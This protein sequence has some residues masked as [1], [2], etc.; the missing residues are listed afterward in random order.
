MRER[1]DKEK[2]LLEQL[3]EAKGNEATEADAK[4]GKGGKGGKGAAKSPME[5]E[6]E[7]EN[8]LRVEAS[9]WILL[10]FPRNLN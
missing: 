7:I 6:D 8:L 1:I 4:G 2:D 9:G 3:E 10:D 5:I